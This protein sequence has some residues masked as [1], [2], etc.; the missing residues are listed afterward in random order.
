MQHC[1]GPSGCSPQPPAPTSQRAGPDQGRGPASQ[2][3]RPPEPN[4]STWTWPRSMALLDC[5]PQRPSHQTLQFPW[6][7]D[8][9]CPGQNPLPASGQPLPRGLDPVTLTHTHTHRPASSHKR[10]A[11]P[12]PPC[13]VHFL[14]RSPTARPLAAPTTSLSPPPPPKAAQSSPRPKT[15]VRLPCPSGSVASP[16]DAAKHLC[17]PYLCRLLSLLWFSHR[18]PSVSQL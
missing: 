1:P 11:A 5:G 6:K 4:L 7:L 9:A 12:D 17:V 14:F 2:P 8:P 3:L 15:Q 16:A 10:P 13:P 18:N